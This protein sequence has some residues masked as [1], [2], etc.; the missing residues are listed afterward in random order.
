MS[1]FAGEPESLARAAYDRRP[2]NAACLSRAA[3]VY[4]LS[5]SVQCKTSLGTDCFVLLSSTLCLTPPAAP[6]RPTARTGSSAAPGRGDLLA[7]MASE[8]PAGNAPPAADGASVSVAS[9]G[10]KPGTDKDEASSLRHFARIFTYND[11]KGWLMNGVAFLCMVAAGT[12]LPLMDIVFGQ[13]V[14][15]FNDFVAGKLSPD[16]YMSQVGHFTC[17]PITGICFTRR[18]TDDSRLYFIYLFVAKFLLTYIGTVLVNIAAIRTTKELRVDFVRQTLRQEISFFDTPSS[19]ISGQI[20][21]NGNL[22]NNGISEKLGVAVQ[23]VSS[24]ATAFIVAFAVQWKLTLIVL[25]TVPLNLVLT[26]LCV[27][28]DTTLEYRMFDIYTH[29]GSLADEAFSTIR[30]AH[31]FW[32]FP[33]L[34][35]RFDAILERAAIIG[36]RKSPLYAVM[37]PIEFFCVIAG[38][39]LAFWQGIRMYASGEITQPGTVVTVI[40]AVLVAAQ[41]LTQIAPQTIAISRAAA[42]AQ[43]LFSVI[44]RQSAVDSLSSEGMTM[45]RFGGDI[46]LRGVEFAYPSRPGV[47]VLRGLDLDIPADKTTALVGAS[48]SGKSTIFGILERWYPFSGGSVTLDGHRLEDL[49]L[50]WLRTNIRLVQQEPT[51]FSG[52]IFQNVVDGLTGTDMANLSD[53]DKERLVRDACKAA[54]AHDFIEELPNARCLIY[55][56]PAGYD[57]YIGERGASLSGGQ[58]QRIV[59]ARSI[60]S[61]P[62]VLLLDE[63]TSALD[64]NAE[65]VVQAAL[66]NVA[67]GR[68]MV[69]IAHRLSTIRDADNIIVMARGGIVESGTHGELLER[70]GAYARLV[71]AQDLG[72]A[73]D[74]AD[75][76]EG[77]DD[78]GGGGEEL[79]VPVTLTRASTA[80]TIS[81][82]SNDK[83]YRY[84]L[85]HGLYLVLK[86]QKSLH[87]MMLV[88]ALCCIGTSGMYPAV[89]VLFSK[90]MDA[91]QTIDVAQGDFFSLM[92]FVVA[93][94]NLVLFAIAGWLSNI[95]AQAVMKFYRSEIFNNTLRQDMVFFDHPEN[96]TGALVSRLAS[97]PTALQ[98]LLSVNIV[99]LMINLASL[100]GSSV[101]AIVVGWKL[102]LVLT[103]GALP[104]LVGAGYMRIRL[105]FKFEDD[106]EG[107]FAESSGIAAEAVMGIRTVSS[108]ALERAVVERYEE[109]LQGIARMAIGSLGWKMVFY[110]LSQSASFLVEA[111]GFWYGGKLMSTGEYTTAQFYTVFIAVVFSGESAAVLFQYTTSITK[112][113]TAIN[114]IF[115]LRRDRAMQD[116]EHEGDGGSSG[117]KTAPAS[118]ETPKGTEVAC[119]AVEFAYP[120]RPGVKVLRGI[121][122]SI[123][124]GKMVA[125]V[126]ASGCGKSTMIALLQ[127]FYDPV[128]G[129]LRANGQ[130][131]AGLDRCRYRRDMA[132]VQQEPVLY[133]GS[134]RD[135]ISLGVEVGDPSEADV[136]AACKSAN[137]WDFV[138]SLPQGLDT[139]CGTQGLSLSGGQR[140]RIAIARALIRRPRLL[141]LDEAT[142]AL[143]TESEKVVKEALDRAAAGRTT[144]AVAHRLSTIRDADLIVVFAKGRIVERGTHDELLDMRGLYYEMVQGQSLDREAV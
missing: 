26:F 76:G 35:A 135:N 134:I 114:Y 53:A 16:A 30:T 58:K 93:L 103:F 118:E 109:R 24:F 102:G 20:A 80:A 119:E 6:S 51:L 28:K 63:A 107:R 124:P 9:E 13:F 131:I 88:I 1:R 96:S 74:K 45:E 56:P 140:Q 91:F 78:D 66:N 38:Y 132:I 104:V 133:Q 29:S 11:A 44:D 126:G 3:S 50:R 99:L 34:A 22:V 12:A 43:D 97:E 46:K 2:R 33:K 59:I 62:R 47:R 101:L 60:I 77:D 4:R 17:V 37:F 72:R 86:E 120:L 27:A 121:D 8:Q 41:A 18:V 48:G 95:L 52:S 70:G 25:A 136:T 108:L 130:D 42:A 143:D 61:N 142:S 36:R 122:A 65:K 144:V 79:D 106:T 73:A 83:D 100:V 67:R 57:T 129:T 64:P 110:A 113:R 139:P 85:F 14:N 69:V 138:A 54:Y 32:A 68:T 81:G 112:A 89:A 128:A 55:T 15:V 141:L 82:P 5:T 90:T 111:L 115:R 98:E 39:G 127:R 21:T 49:N 19:S 94:G 137:V 92:F 71:Q 31:A 7:T 123:R 125:L 23:A 10:L 40:F 105:E 117:E 87:W 75:D 84:G 116:A